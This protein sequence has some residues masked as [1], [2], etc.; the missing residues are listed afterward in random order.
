[1]LLAFVL[2]AA[3][4]VDAWATWPPAAPTGPFS[5][6]D[7]SDTG[8]LDEPIPGFVGPEG[9]G[10]APYEGSNEDQTVNPAFVGWATSVAN[11][12]P[13]GSGNFS[14]DD[15]DDNITYDFKIPENALGP[16]TAEVF[17]VVSL[18]DLSSAD[19]AAKKT[20]GTIT[21]QFDD[22][23]GDGDGPDFAVFENA[24]GVGEN[25][26]AELAYVEVSTNGTDFARF[27]S[28]YTNGPISSDAGG[29]QDPQGIYDLAGKH[30]NGYGV[31]WGTPFDLSELALHPLVLAGNVD[32]N[33]IYYVRFVDIPG[34][35][36]YKDDYGNAIY[37]PWPT[38]G[39]P[40]F[41]LEAVGVLNA[42]GNYTHT[43][44][45][46]PNFVT[47]PVDQNLSAGQ[48]A[49]F[50]ISV[51]GT[52]TPSVHWQRQAAGNSTW[53][54][55]TESSVYAG[56]TSTTLT[57]SN[58]TVLLSGDQ[59]R[60]QASNSAG[61]SFSSAANLTVTGTPA[62]RQPPVTQT[63][64]AGSVATF[65]V[66]AVGGG[67]SYQWRKGSV[68]L[69]TGGRV[70]GT[71]SATLQIA[72][73]SVADAGAYAVMVTNLQGQVLS[74][75]ATL[76]VRVPP[77]LSLQPKSATVVTGKTAKF[78]VAAK[79]T[80]PFT[81]L[82]QKNGKNLKNGAGV[83]GATAATLT[84]GKVSTTS[85]GNYRVVVANAAGKATSVTA[86]LTVKKS[87]GKSR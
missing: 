83:T 45:L 2:V 55:L 49:N 6:G 30:E 16:V 52:P 59:Y 68:D 75:S 8:A 54:N 34:N 73:I 72:N 48:T 80:A 65:T 79:G 44:P 61:G 77:T 18:G 43:S 33:H 62:I 84:L 60:C 74:A 23:I 1:M 15:F 71:D 63:L 46:A 70:F 81:Y 32:L 42:A 87:K 51:V 47:Q 28:Y 67:L 3:W 10:V 76:T 64:N 11:Y 78:T 58:V 86:K 13:T 17:D 12:S 66:T 9:D 26:F 25:D 37:D 31:S 22:G 7:G 40:G 14:L 36:S 57:L 82:W 4:P 41:D 27:P 35:G 38:T 53:V 20:P 39:S 19:I 21:L 69:A 56:T 24:I 29:T 5:A 50:T 85:A